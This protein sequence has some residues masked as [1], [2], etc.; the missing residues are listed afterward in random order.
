MAGGGDG[1]DPDSRVARGRND[2]LLG[3]GWN[4]RRARTWIVML[5]NRV[6]PTKD[7]SF[8]HFRPMLHQ[9]NSQR[10]GFVSAGADLTQ[11]FGQWRG[12]PTYRNPEL[13]RGARHRDVQQAA[14]R[15]S[16]A[17]YEASFGVEQ[18]DVEL[19]DLAHVG[20]VDARDE[21]EVPNG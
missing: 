15:Q 9:R 8:K 20:D 17:G 1:G 14:R 3:C 10:A 18:D 6:H 11:V 4:S 16:A 7:V 13:V 12:A 2:R 21:R 19:E 5:A